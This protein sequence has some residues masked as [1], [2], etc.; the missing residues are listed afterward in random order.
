MAKHKVV[1][2]CWKHGHETEF[3]M[4]RAQEERLVRQIPKLKAVCP[5]CRDETGTN[6]EIFIKEGQ[7]LVSSHKVYKCEDGHPTIIGAFT[8]NMLHTRFG[9]GNDDFENVEGGIDDLQDLV[10]NGDIICNHDGCGKPL[11]AADDSVLRLPGSSN[12]KVKTRL[13]DLWDKAGAEPVRPGSY[14]QN[15]H[16]SDTHSE[17]ANRHRL[18]QMRK[19]NM[20]EDRHPGKRITKATKR[21]YG[22]KSKNDIN[23]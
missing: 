21:Q 17:K 19:R 5:V 2:C 3:L 14:D 22:R 1:V 23:M 20:A 15:G 16:Y 12:F 13:G 6:E 11:R 10:D 8:N 9:P 18:E 7:T 4:T